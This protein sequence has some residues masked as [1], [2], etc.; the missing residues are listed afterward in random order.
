M[1]RSVHLG[2]LQRNNA[3]LK[4]SQDVLSPYDAAHARYVQA[5]I[6]QNRLLRKERELLVQRVVRSEEVTNLLVQELQKSR[7]QTDA[8]LRTSGHAKREERISCGQRKASG[9]P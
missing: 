3:L 6:E 7:A 2:K 5:I 4:N 1:A 8:A 9:L